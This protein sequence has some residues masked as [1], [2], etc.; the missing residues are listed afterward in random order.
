MLAIRKSTELPKFALGN[1]AISAFFAANRPDQCSPRLRMKAGTSRS[2]CSKLP[3]T[4]LF[5]FS[6]EGVSRL[7]IAGVRCIAIAGAPFAGGAL[8]KVCFAG[9]S[10]GLDGVNDDT[11]RAFEIAAAAAV[12][13]PSRFLG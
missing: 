8:G 12:T 7:G 1:G 10:V 3:L 5:T 9:S 13:A 11:E 2:S 6:S 4:L